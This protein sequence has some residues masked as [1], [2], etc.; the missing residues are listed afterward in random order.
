MLMAATVANIRLSTPPTEGLQSK[1]VQQL[2]R[3]PSEEIAL[4]DYTSYFHFY[5]RTCEALYLGVYTEAQALVVDSHDHILTIVQVVWDLIDGS[6]RCTRPILREK[7]LQHQVFNQPK[8]DKA[9]ALNNSINLALRLWLTLNF[10][11][12]SF[13]PAT[14]IISWDDQ[15]TVQEQVACQFQGPRLKPLSGSREV[16][17][18]NN[19]LTAVNLSRL[20]G[21]SIDWTD[22]LKDHLKFDRV[23]KRLLVYGLKRCLYDHKNRLVL[24]VVAPRLYAMC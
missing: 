2:W 17:I 1:I 14:A 4:G 20:G 16:R 5:Q 8:H 21:I 18:L 19:D 9:E 10:Q 12:S 22:S 3:R 24:D 7:L 6:H 11:R 23:S 13:S 15:S